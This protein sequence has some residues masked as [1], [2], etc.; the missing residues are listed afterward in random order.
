[1]PVDLHSSASMSL[2]LMYHELKS[3][4]SL[5][6]AARADSNQWVELFGGFK[7]RHDLLHL[8]MGR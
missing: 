5:Q 3:V 8:L 1:M 4:Y 2:V 7:D 6:D